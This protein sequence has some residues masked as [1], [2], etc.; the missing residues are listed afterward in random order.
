M[1]GAIVGYVIAFLSFRAGLR[2]SYFALITLAFA[3][4]LRIVANSVEIT[5]G[6]LGMLIG[7]PAAANFQFPERIGFY[8]LMLA[9][10]GVSMRSPASGSTASA[11][12][13]RPSA[14]MRIRPARWASTPSPRRS[15]C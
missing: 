9:L 10:R 1:A 2:G 12:N 7:R 11:P 14:R 8:Y 3:E 13:S 15:R 5:G 6:G 4:V